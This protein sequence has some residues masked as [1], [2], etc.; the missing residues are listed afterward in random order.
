[1]GGEQT[2]ANGELPNILFLLTDNQHWTSLGAAGNDIIETPHTDDLA[3]RGALFENAFVTTP[4]CGASR[5]S[6]LTGLYRRSHQ[7]DFRTPPFRSQLGSLTYPALL[8]AAGYYSGFIGK[9]G[10]ESDGYMNVESETD[11]LDRMF[12][13]FDNYE[14]WG[15]DNYYERQPDGTLRHL[16]DVTGD[17][18]LG[19]LR[20]WQRSESDRPFCLS[21]SFNAPHCQDDHPQQYIWPASVDHLYHD[22][23]IPV[24]ETSTADFFDTQPD[25]IKSSENRERWKRRFGTPELFQDNMKGYY[26]MVSGVDRVLGRVLGELEA[27]EAAESTVVIFTSDNGMFFGE[28]GL[29]DCWLLY[30]DSIRVPL[31]IMDPRCGADRQGVRLEELVL[32]IDISPTIIDLAGMAAP[33]EVQGRSMMTLLGDS[34][35]DWRSDFYC[36]HLFEHPLIPKSE[37]M[38]TTRWK[39]IQ[40]VDR[41]ASDEEQR[42]EGSPARGGI[43]RRIRGGN[44]YEELYDLANDPLEAVNVIDD[45]RCQEV[46]ARLVGRFEELRSQAGSARAAGSG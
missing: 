11:T 46:L 1:M 4:I 35:G 39:Y 42:R 17:K 36:E 30:E 29:S 12:H 25:F 37:G 23:V 43:G 28:R 9:F 32:N 3:R 41:P 40:Y 44:R 15:P 8:K 24:P 34:P 16:T 38:R 21:V 26:R 31:I 2:D 33:E 10:I 27:V 22:A 5:A 45:P 13:H 7:F 6:F 19:F 18:I 14:H 20:R